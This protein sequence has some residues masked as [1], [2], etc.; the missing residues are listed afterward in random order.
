MNGHLWVYLQTA[1]LFWLTTTL[2]AYLIADSLGRWAGRHPIVNPVLIAVILIIMILRTTGTAYKTYFEGAQF[3]HFLMGPATVSLGLPLYKNWNLV[4]K[5]FLPIIAALLIGALVAAL[6]ALAVAKLGHVPRG[7]LIS[8]SFK[9]T[10]VG[11]AMAASEKLG[12]LPSLTAVC[13][14]FTGITGAIL[15]T[16]LMNALKVRD[17]AARGFA[18][19]LASHGIGTARALSVDPIAGAFAGIAMGLNTVVTPMLVPLILPWFVR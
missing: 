2:A 8:L 6:S 9:S 17:F 13:V 14:M 15:I 1:P 12:G 5:H 3:V 16:P 4:R 11:V 18:V 7:G 19:G 10:T